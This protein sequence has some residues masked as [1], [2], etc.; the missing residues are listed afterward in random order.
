MTFTLRD[1]TACSEQ[2]KGI[3]FAPPGDTGIIALVL[4]IRTIWNSWRYAVCSS[5]L[6][7]TLS[8]KHIAANAVTQR[9]AY[10]TLPIELCA[11]HS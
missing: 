4:A 9:R 1:R 7:Y 5:N 3:F 11:P 6:T 2:S 10:G 8:V